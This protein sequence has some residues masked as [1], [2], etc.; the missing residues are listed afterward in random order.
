MTNECNFSCISDFYIHSLNEWS[1]H[2]P[3]C[4][5]IRCKNWSESTRDYE[6]VEHTF[7]NLENE[8]F[9]TVKDDVESFC[10]NNNVNPNNESD[11]SEEL[12]FP[13]TVKEIV[14]AI[15]QLKRN[16]AHGIDN[17]LNEYFIECSDILSPYLCKLF[18]AVLD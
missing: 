17:L 2:T 5:S 14:S 1:D 6:S 7:S 16:K 11:Y 13:I 12:D 9:Q 8:I 10:L 15:K 18:N 3:R 4:F